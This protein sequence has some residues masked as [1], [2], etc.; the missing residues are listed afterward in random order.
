MPLK[1]GGELELDK[2][3][4][5]TTI[6]PIKN[7]GENSTSAPYYTNKISRSVKCQNNERL[8]GC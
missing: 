6:Q 8:L 7:G 5:N 1:L 3:L 2:N 4:N